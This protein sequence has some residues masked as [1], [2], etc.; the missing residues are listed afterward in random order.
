MG[1]LEE[2]LGGGERKSSNQKTFAQESPAT[3]ASAAPLAAVAGVAG[4][5]GGKVFCGEKSVR[6]GQAAVRPTL[7]ST[8][9]ERMQADA[10]NRPDYPAGMIPWLGE[11]H[12]DLY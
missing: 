10:I 12:Q 5:V 1:L 8:Y 4:D 3:A 7:A 2:L 9:G 6:T 11:V